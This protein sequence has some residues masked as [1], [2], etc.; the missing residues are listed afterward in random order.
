L[1]RRSSLTDFCFNA[2]AALG[3]RRDKTVRARNRDFFRSE[4]KIVG[5]EEE[6]TVVAEHDI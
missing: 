2:A 5:H 4:F 1:S 6:S 3:S